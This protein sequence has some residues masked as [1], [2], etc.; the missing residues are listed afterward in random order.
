MTEKESWEKVVAFVSKITG[1]KEPQDLKG[2]L[3]LIGVQ[4]LGKGPK[5]FSREQKQDLMHIAVCEIFQDLGYYKYSHRDED[6]W[7]HY[8]V[9]DKIPHAKLFGQE[10]LIKQQIIAYF[11]REQL[12]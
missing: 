6:G 5:V 7:P 11:E 9:L 12:I 10:D 2:Y 3:F 4:T 1:G 8:E